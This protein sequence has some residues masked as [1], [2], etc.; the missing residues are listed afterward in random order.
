[1]GGPLASSHGREGNGSPLAAVERFRPSLLLYFQRRVRDRAE[2]EDLVQDVFVRLAQRGDL[3]NIDRLGGYLFETAANVLRDRSRRRQVRAADAH[4]FFDSER[5]GGA[6]FAPDRV[7][8]GQ[9]RLRRAGAALL[10]LPERT[11]HVFVLRRLE[12]MRYQEVASRLGISVSA[13]E[14]HMH[15]AM[16][17]LLQQLGEE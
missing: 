5:H 11:R 1:M 3:N 13:V 7:L 4:E 9:E 6:D 17:H 2:A 15:R 12:G 14:K 16:A 10:E 8:D